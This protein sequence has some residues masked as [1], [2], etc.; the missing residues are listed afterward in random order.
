[1]DMTIVKG[2]AVRGFGF[3]IPPSIHQQVAESAGG[4][5]FSFPMCT[6]VGRFCF[7]GAAELGE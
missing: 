7:V 5:G 6:Q 3:Y 4:S 2:L 1:M